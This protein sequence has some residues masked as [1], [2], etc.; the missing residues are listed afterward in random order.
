MPDAPEDVA[1]IRLESSHSFSDFSNSPPADA[2]APSCL[3]VNARP[4]LRRFALCVIVMRS[5][6]VVD[7]YAR[8]R[9]VIVV[10]A[11]SDAVQQ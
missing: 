8:R 11:L 5:Q 10:A 7:A 4:G 9:D 6:G 3:D 1:G 2:R